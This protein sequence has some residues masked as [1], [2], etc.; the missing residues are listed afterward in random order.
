MNEKALAKN[1]LS[2]EAILQLFAEAKPM[3]L[4]ARSLKELMKGG[5]IH[6]VR[7]DPRFGKGIED[8]AMHVQSSAEPKQKLLALTVL[9]RI[10]SR[11]K[12]KRNDLVQ[13]M[14]T[15]LQTPLPG[16]PELDDAEDR[17]YA[18][19]ALKWASGDWIVPYLARSIVE[20][21][22]GEKARATLVQILLM[23]SSN[24]T[25]AFDAL[26]EPLTEWKPKTEAKGDS[27]AR[28]LKRILS[29]IR[30]ELLLTEAPTGDNLG[31]TIKAFIAAAFRNVGPPTSS[32]SA[33]G[34]TVEIFL[35]LHYLVRTRLSLAAEGATYQALHIPSRWFLKGRWPE[36]CDKEREILSRDIEEAIARL[37]KQSITDDSLLK[38]LDL[39]RGSRENALKVTSRIADQTT[40]LTDNVVEW[41][42]RGRVKGAAQG[43]KLMT[44]SNQLAADP[45]LALLLIDSSRVVQ[46]LDGPG[47]DLL[48]EVRIFEPNLEPSAKAFLDRVRMLTEGLNT[49]AKKRF[50]RIRGKI[51]E[52]VDYSPNEHEAVGAPI[53]GTRRVRIVRPLVERVR[54]EK[55]TEIVIKAAVEPE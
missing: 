13:K 49:L 52:V 22:S 23:K 4:K 21:E 1:E 9:A 47:Q 39:I 32:E 10:A 34:L 17:A 14:E 45:T 38:I 16:L 36:D 31:E 18:A 3:E 37:A 33:T 53:A 6:S 44:E 28:R 8:A 51:G 7:D 5:T 54:D 20:E 15:I 27:A 2:V 29:A 26:R 24:L 19:Q 46:M 43:Q 50:L 12:A 35:F 30:P 55:I 41:L 48:N 40:G 11:I 42:R 25:S